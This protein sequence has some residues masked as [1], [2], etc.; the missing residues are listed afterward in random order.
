M[1][2]GKTPSLLETKGLMSTAT[3][4]PDSLQVPSSSGDLGDSSRC[5]EKSRSASTS[6]LTLEV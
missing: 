5:Y 1:A 3:T 2:N 6:I 4:F